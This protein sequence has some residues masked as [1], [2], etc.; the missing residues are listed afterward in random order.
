MKQTRRKQNHAMQ[1]EK[2][3]ML[4]ALMIIVSTAIEWSSLTAFILLLLN[5]AVSVALLLIF[6]RFTKERG[7]LIASAPYAI[8]LIISFGMLGV[9]Y[10]L[11]YNQADG[12]IVDS[13]V[14]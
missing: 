10:H 14:A 8:Y 12:A 2:A 7:T 11:A 9:P 6:S 13:L 5:N 3:Q 4:S 1:L